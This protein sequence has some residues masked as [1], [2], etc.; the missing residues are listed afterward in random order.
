MSDPLFSY[1]DRDAAKGK[2][3]VPRAASFWVIQIKDFL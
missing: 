2:I 1:L 3:S